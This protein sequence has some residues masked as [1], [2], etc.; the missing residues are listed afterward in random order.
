MPENVGKCLSNLSQNSLPPQD[1]RAHA[2]G[3]PL[4]ISHQCASSQSDHVPLHAPW[5][6]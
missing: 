3:D 5:G 6:T 4:G 2:G 1:P